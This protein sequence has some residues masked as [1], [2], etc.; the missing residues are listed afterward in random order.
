MT[1]AKTGSSFVFID[2]AVEN[3]QSLAEGV[4]DAHVYILDA[5]GDGIKQITAIL[6]HAAQSREAIAVDSIHIVSHGAPGCLYLGNTQLSLDTLDRNA[7]E[8]AAWFSGSESRDPSLLLY[9]CNVAVGDAGAELVDRLHQ[10][11][12]AEIAASN[13][14]TGSAALGGNWQLEVQTGAVAAIA[15]DDVT[16]DRYCGVLVAVKPGDV[17]LTGD[18]IDD[19]TSTPAAPKPKIANAIWSLSNQLGTDSGLPNSGVADYSPGFGVGSA[20]LETGSAGNAGV[21][22]GLM[23]YINNQNFVASNTGDLTGQTLTVNGNSKFAGLDVSVQYAAM[24]DKPTLR[25][26]ASFTNSTNAAITTTISWVTNL[27][28]AF[29]SELKAASNAPDLQPTW[30]QYEGTFTKDARW[31]IIDDDDRPYEGEKL[32][33]GRGSI[34]FR[35][36]VTDVLF[37]PGSPAV[38]PSSVSGTTFFSNGND[39]NDNRGVIA[40]YQV[41]IPANS[42]RSLL[43]FYGL[44]STTVQAKAAIGVYNDVT[45]LKNAGD[46]VGLTD[47]QLSETLNWSLTSPGVTVTPT[48]GLQ[49]TEAGGTANFTVVLTS[50]PT[51]DVTI[52][53][54]SSDLTEGTVPQ[55]VSFSAANWFTPQTVAVQGVD[56]Q[57]KDGNTAYTIQTKVAS[58]DAAY[59]AIDPT[60]VSVINLDNDT[61]SGGTGGGTGGGGNNGGGG[62][63][64]GGGNGGNDG[65]GNNGNGGGNNP[66]LFVVKGNNRANRLMG[67][68]RNDKLLGYNGNDRLVGG[69]GNDSLDGGKNRDT[70]FGGKGNDVLKGGKDTN[71]LSGGANRDV[72]VLEPGATQI[73]RDFQNNVDKL[74]LSGNLKFNDLDLIKRGRNTIVKKDNAVLG[75]LE[76]VRPSLISSAD[77]VKV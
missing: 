27:G 64:N 11:T 13:T 70:L 77:F 48:T 29:S 10:I 54:T 24:Q 36:A 40:S 68:S 69:N 35:P 57:I 50:Q 33:E 26:F 61:A 28:H 66:P 41:T 62:G 16:C 34:Y 18:I 9:G 38:K 32:G 65:G 2:A 47:K 6:R 74:G 75:I 72:F 17:V 43:F 56:D 20:N 37:G 52:N 21:T 4:S 8:L 23:L 14:L 5:T 53:L 7:S 73:I 55:S 19:P 45:A 58:T 39:P 3:Y 46:L 59:T 15:F 71:F 25:T 42:T 67:T 49:T 76:G 30:P 1:F 51:A 63:N 22:H 44:N 12:G 60:D 31:L